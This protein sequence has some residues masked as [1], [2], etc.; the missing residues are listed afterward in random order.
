MAEH[1]YGEAVKV[2]PENTGAMIGLAR[3]FMEKDPTLSWKWCE[4][5]YELRPNKLS[6]LRF[7]GEAALRAG[8]ADRATELFSKALELE[9]GL[10]PG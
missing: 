4:R 3:L 9:P 6:V 8:K 5:A 1:A 2:D 10:Y 7:A